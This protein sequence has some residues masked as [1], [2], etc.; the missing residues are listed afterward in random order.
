MLYR[1]AFHSLF[2]FVI[3]LLNFALIQISA[4]I[5]PWQ[6]KKNQTL[7][8][9]A[10]QRYVQST[11]IYYQKTRM[12]LQCS[13]S[14]QNTEMAENAYL[15]YIYGWRH[16]NDSE[17]MCCH[18]TVHKQ[19]SLASA[20]RS[21]ILLRQTVRKHNKLVWKKRVTTFDMGETYKITVLRRG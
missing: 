10:T 21:L 13:S 9:V 17:E 14:E 19:W 4:T 7:F 18:S 5:I 12:N 20:V 1:L 15:I 11:V 16:W 2:T 3:I 6:E 8:E